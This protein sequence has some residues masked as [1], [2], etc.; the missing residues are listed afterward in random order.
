[1]A[2][3]EPVRGYDRKTA[4]EFDR[5]PTRANDPDLTP[6]VEGFTDQRTIDDWDP[7]FPYDKRSLRPQDDEYWTRHRTTPK[8][9]VPLATSRVFRQPFWRHDV[10]PRAGVGSRT[11]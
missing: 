7:P 11:G 10:D 5:P 6:T 3:T 2:L 1:M 4:A 9:Y 8:A